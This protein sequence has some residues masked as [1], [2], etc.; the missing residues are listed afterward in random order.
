[1]AKGASAA[2]ERVRFTQPALV[3]GAVGLVMAPR[4][5]LFLVLGFT[6]TDDKVTEI[7]IIA[8]PERLRDL[9]LAALDV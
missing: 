9:D 1:M 5:K 8:D 6:I 2:S 4:G 7:D 3:N